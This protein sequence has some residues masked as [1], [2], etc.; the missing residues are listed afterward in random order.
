MVSQVAKV[1][2]SDRTVVYDTQ[3]TKGCSSQHEPDSK[4]YEKAKI[5][6]ALASNKTDAESKLSIA[7]E[8][9]KEAKAHDGIWRD[10]HLDSLAE[11]KAEK[12][13]STIDQEIKLLSTISRQR[14]QARNI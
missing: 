11:A 7:H 5:P 2:H 1:S 12:N 14:R 10:E 8:E 6:N 3:E 13:G 9:Y 4:I